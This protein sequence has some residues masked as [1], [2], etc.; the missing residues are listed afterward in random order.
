[1][2][3]QEAVGGSHE[4]QQ[5]VGTRLIAGSRT[6]WRITRF[7][8]IAIIFAAVLFN[9]GPAYNRVAAGVT[10]LFVVMML[11]QLHPLSYG[12]IE[13]DGLRYRRYFKWRKVGWEQ[14]E[15]ISRSPFRPFASPILVDLMNN[16]IFNRRISFPSNPV[17]FGQP[18]GDADYE[19]LRKSWLAGI[20]KQSPS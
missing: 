9:S 7:G 10:L 13:S 8:E 19:D 14:I 1:M 3:E 17:I 11:A 6:P 16:S 15:S 4:R 18:T 20:S 12:F 2:L 5:P